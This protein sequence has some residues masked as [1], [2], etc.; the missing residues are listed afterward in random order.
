[1]K[2][3]GPTAARSHA[4][5]ARLAVV[6]AGQPWRDPKPVYASHDVKYVFDPISRRL[7][8]VTEWF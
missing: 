8:R 2:K 4:R 6:L 1:M 5:S 3:E 7:V